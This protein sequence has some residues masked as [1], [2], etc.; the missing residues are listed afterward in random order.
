MK[1]PLLDKEFLKELDAHREKEIYAR[2]TSLTFDEHPIEY[3]E[4]RVTGGSI[5][6]DGSSSVRRTCNLTLFCKDIN[7]NDYYW[8]LTTK[9]KVEIG[10]Q[11]NLNNNYPD[12]IWFPQGLFV[13]TAFNTAIQTNGFTVTV[14]GKDKGCLL[15][16]DI[17]GKLPAS[18]DFGKL[19]TIDYIFENALI[20][21]SIYRTYTYYISKSDYLRWYHHDKYLIAMA[22]E[23]IKD[24][25]DEAIIELT[26]SKG[27]DNYILDHKVCPYCNHHGRLTSK[28]VS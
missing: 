19:E 17:G 28:E 1:N 12:I 26:G 27:K 23:E 21:K 5:N 20:N 24:A 22:A 14:N 6:V 13:I 25:I 9:I 18:I 8:G 4:G 11:N 15:N 16:G 10:L 3:I 7:I 2:I